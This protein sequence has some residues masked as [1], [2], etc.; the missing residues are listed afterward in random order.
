MKPTENSAIVHEVQ[1]DVSN[2]GAIQAWLVA[3]PMDFIV[4]CAGYESPT[5]GLHP[6][7]LQEIRALAGLTETL[8]GIRTMHLPDEED[9]PHFLYLSSASVYGSNNKKISQ[10]TSRLYP[11]SYSGMAKLTAED[12]IGRLCSRM[13]VDYSILRLTEVYGRRHHKELSNDGFWPGYLAYYVDQAVHGVVNNKPLDVFS[14]KT[15][16]DLVNV[17]YVTKVMVDVIANRRTGIFNVGSGNHY[18]LKELAYKV[19]A[20]YSVSSA[21]DVLPT[22]DLN[23]RLK[24]EDITTD[25]TKIHELV[26]YS[27]DYNLDRFLA[28]YIKVRRFEVAKGMAIEQIMSQKYTLDS[29]AYGSKEAYR[30]RQKERL[31][32]TV[33][34]K[35]VAGADQFEKIE[36]GR[37]QER[38]RNLLS[39]TEN[40]LLTAQEQSH[41]E[42]HE[43]LRETAL[44][45]A[46]QPPKILEES[47]Q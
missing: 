35:Q 30:K 15:T 26:K 34:I 25:C 9:R 45:E 14:P 2:P 44:A 12:L 18:T 47:E 43:K 3:N 33:Q 40:R 16:V 6:R 31:L 29:T 11:A 38:A 37:F 5:D 32:T 28:D 24:I 27:S 22:L 7:Y 21:E 20:Q 8:E 17:N 10:E 4:Y 41:L 23:S 13:G 46:S 1:L 39:G 19:A 42:Q 36:Y